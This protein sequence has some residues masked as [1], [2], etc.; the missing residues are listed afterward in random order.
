[1]AYTG[2]SFSDKLA[3]YVNQI[4]V[5]GLSHVFQSDGFGGECG[6]VDELFF[7]ILY[8]SP[9]DKEKINTLDCITMK[10]VCSSK[11]V[12]TVSRQATQWEKILAIPISN[13]RLVSRI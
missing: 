8:K 5:K 7:I 3:I 11:D 1:M 2:P 6:K 4:S 9:E 10:D 12:K 13:Q